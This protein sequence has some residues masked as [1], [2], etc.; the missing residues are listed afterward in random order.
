[1]PRVSSSRRQASKSALQRQPMGSRGWPTH[2]SMLVMQVEPFCSS[3]EGRKKGSRP[4]P[5]P[6][7]QEGLLFPNPEPSLQMPIQHLHLCPLEL[8]SSSHLPGLLSHT[9]AQA[10]LNWV[11][12]KHPTSLIPLH[13]TL[14][15]SHFSQAQPAFSTLKD[16]SERFPMTV[17]HPPHLEA[18]PLIFSHKLSSPLP[19]GSRPRCFFYLEYSCSLSFSWEPHVHP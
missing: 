16:G 4:T 6:T 3:S 10:W 8:C 15:P 13:R 2:P 1:M 18:H 7:L 17:T 9:Q 5:L 12:L 14:N 11:L 19:L